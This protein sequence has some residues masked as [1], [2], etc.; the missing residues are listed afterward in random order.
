MFSQLT[1]VNIGRVIISQGVGAFLSGSVAGGV[2]GIG[3]EAS[4]AIYTSRYLRER[5]PIIYEKLKS[6]GDFDLFYYLI[7]DVVRP[8]EAA[9]EIARIHPEEFDNICKYFF[10]GL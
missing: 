8:Y 9:C 6:M 5:N 3:A 10:G 4:R 1:G 2:L 7:E